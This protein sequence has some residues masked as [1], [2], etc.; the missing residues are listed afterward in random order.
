MLLHM[1]GHANS[2]HSPSIQIKFLRHFFIRNTLHELLKYRI[3]FLIHIIF[4][5]VKTGKFIKTE[6]QV[7]QISL[8]PLAYR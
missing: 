5:F 8:T 1:A 7:T 4:I 2:A 3:K 6:W